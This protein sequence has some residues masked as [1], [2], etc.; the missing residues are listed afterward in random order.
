M[1]KA[2]QSHLSD[3]EWSF[4]E[5]LVPSPTATGRPKLHSAR[6]ILNAVFY[7]VR[8]GCAWRLL[9]GDCCRMTSLRQEDPLPLLPL[10][11]LGRNM[12]EDALSP[13]QEASASSPEE[14]PPAQ[15]AA[16]VDS[17]SVKTTGVGGVNVSKVVGLVSLLS[18][19]RPS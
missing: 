18:R 8:G 5:P 11:A 4:L 9:P 6:E 3:E 10:L 15:R 16:I 1:R 14:E 7:I 12:G 19:V 17:Q 13:A 2:C